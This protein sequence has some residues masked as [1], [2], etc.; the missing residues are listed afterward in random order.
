ME[1]STAMSFLIDFFTGNGAVW[2]IACVALGVALLSLGI[3]AGVKV[4]SLNSTIE[5]QKS[6]YKNSI[7]TLKDEHKEAIKVLEEKQAKLQ[8]EKED[9]QDTVSKVE[10]LSAQERA[11][12]KRNAEFGAKKQQEIKRTY[13]ERLKRFKE[14]AKEVKDYGESDS[15]IVDAAGI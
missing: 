14:K 4:S 2:K 11:D 12:A 10:A 13:E 1:R 3:Y 6:G 9:L 5:D 15:S 8:K 7:K